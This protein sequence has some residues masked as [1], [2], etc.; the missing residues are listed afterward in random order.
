MRKFSFL[1]LCLMMM[2]VQVWAQTRE[3]TGR[4]V[5]LNDGSPRVGATVKL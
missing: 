3:V 4:V 2:V 5:D 1:L